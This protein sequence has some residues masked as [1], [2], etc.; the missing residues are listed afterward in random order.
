LELQAISPKIFSLILFLLLSSYLKHDLSFLSEIKKDFQW[1]STVEVDWEILEVE[2]I[3]KI[4]RQFL[5]LDVQLG[6]NSNKKFEVDYR[7]IGSN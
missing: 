5:N 3:E 2:H 7:V 4:G 1:N 6:S